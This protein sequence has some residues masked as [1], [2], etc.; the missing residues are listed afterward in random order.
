MNKMIIPLCVALTLLACNNEHATDENILPEQEHFPVQCSI[1]N[2][3]ARELFKWNETR[4][5]ILRTEHVSN[6]RLSVPEL[7]TSSIKN[8]TLIITAPKSNSETDIYLTSIGIQGDS[9]TTT[10]HV[11]ASDNNNANNG[12]DN[13][14]NANPF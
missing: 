4:S 3:K 1:E 2:I 13:W 6:H 8:D 9:I 10:L 7:W 14:G 11:F 12:L 5:F